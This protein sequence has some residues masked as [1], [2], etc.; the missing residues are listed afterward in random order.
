MALRVSRAEIREII[1][2]NDFGITAG[3]SAVRRGCSNVPFF[4]GARRPSVSSAS[5]F[6]FPRRKILFRVGISA[7]PYLC[8][9]ARARTPALPRIS[10]G[11]DVNN[12]HRRPPSRRGANTRGEIT[13]RA[14]LPRTSGSRGG[15]EESAHR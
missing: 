9:L 13:H 11:R 10:R 4:T 14:Y 1:R 5:Y 7:R 15:F 2:A 8:Y 6:P 12:H 3:L